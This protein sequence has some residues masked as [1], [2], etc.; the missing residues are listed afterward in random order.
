M[1]IRLN[2]TKKENEELKQY[3]SINLEKKLEADYRK[4]ENLMLPIL[5]KERGLCLNVVI[6]LIFKDWYQR[7]IYTRQ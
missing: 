2:G 5:I 6:K 3:I 1:Q 4:K 7:K